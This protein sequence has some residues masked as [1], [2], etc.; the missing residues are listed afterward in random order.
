MK[1]G[2][3]GRAL[4]LGGCL[5][6]TESRAAGPD[7]VTLLSGP[8]L[9]EGSPAD[10]AGTVTLAGVQD[11]L[12]LDLQHSRPVRALLLQADGNDVYWVEGSDDAQRW[13]TLWRVNAYGGQPGLR[14]RSTL[15]ATPVH[16]RFVRVR[17]TAGDGLYTVARLRLEAEV[18]E[19]W[20][21]PLVELEGRSLPPFPALTP[22]V[23][24]TLRHALGGL[25][26]L[27]AGWGLL[28]RQERPAV[29]RWRRALLVLVASLS[30]LGWPNF[31]NF[32]YYVGRLHLHE[33]FH[34]FMGAK[35]LPEIGYTGLYACAALAEREDGA[36]PEEDARPV[37]DL[38]SNQATTFGHAASE[39]ARLRAHFDPG[40]W[41][42]FR[43]DA[44]WFR[45]QLGARQ[46]HEVLNDHGFNAAPA[47][48]LLARPLAQA[49]PLSR[50]HLEW[51]GAL[52]LVLLLATLLLIFRSFGLEATCL[53]AIYWGLNSFS[54]F[55]WTGGAILRLDWLCLC[56][57][58]LCALR[59]GRP[60]LA[61]LAV[62]YAGLMRLFPFGLAVGVALQGLVA[63][64]EARSLRP[65][66]DQ[67]RFWGGLALA[68]L[69]LL[70]LSSWSAGGWRA[71]PEFVANS[72][73]FL[74]TEASNFLGLP[75]VAAYRHDLRQ[76]LTYDPLRPEPLEVWERA[77]ADAARESRPAVAL[78]AL[79]F[80][81]LLAL[82]VRRNPTWV[83]ALLGLGLAPI[84]QKLANYYFS[85]LLVYALLAELSPV[86]GFALTLVAWASNL[87]ADAFPAYDERALWSSLLVCGLVVGLTARLAHRA[88]PGSGPPE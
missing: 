37:R 42:E 19:P 71:W 13:A 80:V 51:L 49:G 26:L 70:P 20:P 9:P 48:L 62:G 85:W 81:V 35:Y 56:V 75:V 53:A 15:L 44:R 11:A 73:R 28:R 7:P 10:V 43:H 45:Q 74:G 61:G 79:A 68:A 16:L 32:H 12:L 1:L 5:A 69:V 21:P 25:A 4:L 38:A 78:A 3:L 83:A 67:A 87:A 84:V 40:R 72:R 52:D 24:L 60:L 2:R 58:A 47:W 59:R 86:A 82:A 34:Y 6:A 65:F 27:A 33:A 29:T 17:A 77:Q 64:I 14:T 88:T 66:K 57:A 36:A 41:E 76:E 46:W 54:R 39:A 63:A 30:A 31:G 22:Q 8:L 50:F 18:P 55:A 23:V